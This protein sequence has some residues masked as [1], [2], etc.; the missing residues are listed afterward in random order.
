MSSLDLINPVEVDRA[1]H[2]LQP[3][4]SPL[5]AVPV[6]GFSMDNADLVDHAAAEKTGLDTSVLKNFCPITNLSTI[7][8]I[9]EQL[10]SNRMKQCIA[11][12]PSFG[13]LQSTYRQGH[14]RRQYL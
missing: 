6:S 2:H 12:S 11:E 10:A 9:L 1:I 5:D 4:T 3:H 7:S 13:Q 14:P 8:K